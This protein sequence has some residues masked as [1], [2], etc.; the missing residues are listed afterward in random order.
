MKISNSAQALGPV[1][2]RRGVDYW[3]Q[4]RVKVEIAEENYFRATVRGTQKYTTIV[5]PD[6]D[7]I[8]RTSCNCPYGVGC[9]HTAALLYEIRM[10]RK[11]ASGQQNAD[12]SSRQY[13]H[14]GTARYGG[15]FPKRKGTSVLDFLESR[16]LGTKPHGCELCDSFGPVV[17]S[18]Y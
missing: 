7:E 5:E 9:K 1:I 12:G 2:Y 14:Q 11:A 18:R 15:G 16:W 6:G 8:T 13:P 17:E 4:G 10:R 3:K